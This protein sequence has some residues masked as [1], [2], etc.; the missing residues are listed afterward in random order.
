MDQIII[1]KN[2]ADPYVAIHGSLDKQNLFYYQ[3]LTQHSIAKSETHFNNRKRMCC[4]KISLGVPHWSG[5][6]YLIGGQLVIAVN[7]HGTVDDT[8]AGNRLEVAHFQNHHLWKNENKTF[9]CYAHLTWTN[10][11]CFILNQTYSAKTWRFV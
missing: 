3:L 1:L 7:L 5:G 4:W 2:F 11:F 10:L 9:G 6:L 8:C